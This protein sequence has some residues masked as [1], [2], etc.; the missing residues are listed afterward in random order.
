MLLI[1]KQTIWLL[2]ISLVVIQL[3]LQNH[4]QSTSAM[5]KMLLKML[6][7]DKLKTIALF[8]YADVHCAGSR[9]QDQ[10]GS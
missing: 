1:R 9:N 10:D 7:K 8:M 2:A 5:K 3:I 6:K 4:L